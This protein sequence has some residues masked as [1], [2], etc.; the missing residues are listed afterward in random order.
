[1]RGLVA[2][3]GTEAG[4]ER[5]FATLSAAGLRPETYSPLPPA[6]VPARS[7]ISWVMLGAAVVLGGCG[8]FALQSYAFVFNYRLDIGGRPYLSW[9][10]YLP[11]TFFGAVLMAMIAGF[12]SFL[13][14]C[15][16]PHLYDEIDE[17]DGIREATRDTWFVAVR[18]EEQEDIH[19]AHELVAP[20]DPIVM[21]VLAL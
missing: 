13:I 7:R 2:G 14:A 19:F 11:L 5:A 10:D 21:R 12:A 20:L 16:L 4:M 9:P 15:R 6:A 1:M 8:F 3:F 18:T 17:V